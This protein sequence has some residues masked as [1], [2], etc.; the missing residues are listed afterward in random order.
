MFSEVELK[1][2]S[3][4]FS[5][6]PFPIDQLKP[7]IYPGRFKIDPCLDDRTPQHL[8]VGVSS[9]VVDVPGRKTA[10]R[11]TQSSI[12]IANS[13]V[14]DLMDSML[15]YE[16]EAHPGICWLQGEISLQKFLIEHKDKHEE[17]RTVQKKWF[18]NIVKKTEDDWKKYKNSRVVSDSARFAVR[19]LGIELPEWMSVETIGLE[20]VR[21]PACSTMNDPNNAWCMNCI[22]GG[23]KV[24][25]NEEKFKALKIA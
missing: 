13:I 20:H 3:T 25:L 8:V 21:C 2:K 18:I 7:G 9:Y 12:L 4:V 1:D 5:I 15:W 6:C 17:M 19:Y 10:L 14:R 11:M 23:I 22:Q 16:P 24:I